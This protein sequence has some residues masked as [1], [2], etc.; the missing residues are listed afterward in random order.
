MDVIA[1][2]RAIH[3]LGVVVWIGGMAMVTAVILPAI[4]RGELGRDPRKAFHAIERRFVWVARSAVL[5]V[6]IS[7]FYM[8]S[9][10][11]I[12]SRFRSAGFWWMH[13][14][15]CLWLLFMI[16]LFVAEPFF[17]HRHLEQW[18]RQ[19]PQAVFAWLRRA[20][21]VF[22]GVALVT[23]FGAVAGSHGWRF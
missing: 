5:L 23:I 7:G 17:L 16:I 18:W 13:A 14:M 22:L 8:A 2:A 12:W 6:G 4:G 20:H 9:M 19:S 21:W 10:L 15:V 11:G 1:M 3:V